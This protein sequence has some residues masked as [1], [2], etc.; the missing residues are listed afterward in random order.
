MA[1]SLTPEKT[2]TSQPKNLPHLN[3]Y[4]WPIF[5]FHPGDPPSFLLKQHKNRSSC[6]KIAFDI[7]LLFSNQ[8]KEALGTIPTENIKRIAAF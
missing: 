5:I 2:Q 1:R 8:K 4:F 6:K 3:P 7:L